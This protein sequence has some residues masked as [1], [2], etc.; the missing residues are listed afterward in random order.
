M[1]T[2]ID[3]VWPRIATHAGEKFSLKTGRSL[4][5]TV[6]GGHVHP[7][8]AKHQQI[9]KSHFQ[10]APELVPLS[11]PGEISQL[12]RGSSYV[13]AILMDPRIRQGDW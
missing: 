11:G 7:D 1:S 12:V 8:R 3:I 10:S 9:P 4:T 13:Y 5:Y 2:S 6:S